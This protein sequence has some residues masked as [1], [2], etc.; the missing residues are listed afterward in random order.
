MELYVLKNQEGK[1]FRA[2]GYGG[3][4]ETWVPEIKSAR[5]YGNLG[6]ARTQVTFFASKHPAH[7]VPE[8]IVL[9]VTESHVLDE[10]D[11]V[12]KALAKLKK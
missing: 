5:L 10:K 3:S 12:E 2:K 9:R 1:Y 11:R 6:P 8:I 4:G 7:G